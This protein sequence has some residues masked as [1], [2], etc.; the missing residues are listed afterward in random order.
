LGDAQEKRRGERQSSG[1]EINFS[2][3]AT[4]TGNNTNNSGTRSDVNAV[5]KRR[6]TK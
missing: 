2:D 5:N 3:G 1:I 6:E 4:T